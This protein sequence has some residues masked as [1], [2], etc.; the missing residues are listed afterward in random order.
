MQ[1]H[2]NCVQT[3]LADFSLLLLNIIPFKV[4]VC[5]AKTIVQLNIYIIYNKYIKI[6]NNI[7]GQ[8]TF[9]STKDV[10]SRS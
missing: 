10:F 6:K 8:R 7:F 9:L 3:D 5:T 4:N 2:K 1:N